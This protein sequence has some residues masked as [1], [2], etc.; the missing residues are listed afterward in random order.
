MLNADVYDHSVKN[1]EL[2]ETHISW[3]VLTGEYAYKIKKPVNF[4][5]LDFS[6]LPKRH[7]FCEQEILLNRRLAPGVYLGVVPI[8]AKQDKLCLSGRG[9]P[10]EYAVKMRQFPQS[11]QLDN[12]L[13]SGELKAEHID[14][15]ARVT[16]EFHQRAECADE[17]TD[18]GE[19]QVVYQPVEENFRQIHEHINTENY[20]GVLTTLAQWSHAEFVKLGPLL[21]QRKHDGFI[22]QC[23]GDMHLRNLI[24]F[25]NQPMAF[26]CIE[27]NPYLSWIDVISEVAFLM[28]D[29]QSRNEY[30]LANRFIN[31][32]L[33]ITGDYAGLELMRFYLCYRA[34]VRAKVDALRMEQKDC[35]EEESVK[36]R[37]EF[38]SYLKLATAYTHAVTPK[39][40]IMHGV[41]AVGKST[42]SQELIDEMGVIRIRSD[43]ERKRLFNVEI[44]SSASSEVNSGLYTSQASQ[45]TYERLS[46]LAE[47]VISAGYNVVVDATF[48]EYTQRKIFQ[49][50]AKRLNIPYIILQ[51]TAS[52]DVLKKRISQRQDTISDADIEVLEHQLSNMKPFHEEEM[53]S[54]IHV[55]TETEIDF[56]KLKLMLEFKAYS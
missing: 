27:F 49:S 18:Y 52:V 32:Y 42:V 35:P 43:V 45:Q 34:L 48:L 41:S 6:T 56:D 26:D 23:H 55:N 38:E 21:E 12:M 30:R 10:I 53:K 3:V 15:L 1:L 22:R 47:S 17:T 54:L 46:E 7:K 39:L 5:F 14:A 25:D 20:E 31:S 40:I 2:I 37:T 9:E 8:V 29:L 24:W 51:L 50:L 16:A 13:V 28:M 33:Q 4:G 44:E 19:A 11:A 36:T